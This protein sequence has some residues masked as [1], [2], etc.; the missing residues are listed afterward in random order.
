MIFAACSEGQSGDVISTWKCP[1]LGTSTRPGG[2][3]TRNGVKCIYKQF[4]S[5][6]GKYVKMFQNEGMSYSKSNGFPLKSTISVEDFESKSLTF[7]GTSSPS[8]SIA[9]W[10]HNNNSQAS[11]FVLNQNS[12]ADFKKVCV[13]LNFLG[14]GSVQVVFSNICP[15]LPRR[16]GRRYLKIHLPSTE[17]LPNAP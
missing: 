10:S 16:A 11:C 4:M 17:F 9:G 7:F 13:S 12:K 3:G 2:L 5:E 14:G 15:S 6:T 8:A 1:N